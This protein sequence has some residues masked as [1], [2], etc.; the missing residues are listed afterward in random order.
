[1]ID[2]REREKK[3]ACFPFYAHLTDLAS[4]LLSSDPPPLILSSAHPLVL[5]LYIHTRRLGR[6]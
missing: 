1:M 5:A 2:K 6:L 3:D 4:P